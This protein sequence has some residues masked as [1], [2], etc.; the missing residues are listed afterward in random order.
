MANIEGPPQ[1]TA[2]ARRSQRTRS[3]N[4]AL[5]ALLSIHIG[6]RDHDLLPLRSGGITED[7]R[8]LVRYRRELVKVRNRHINYTAGLDCRINGLVVEI[9]AT[10]VAGTALTDIHDIQQIAHTLLTCQVLREATP[11]TVRFRR[12]T[13][14]TNRHLTP[15]DSPYAAIMIQSPPEGL[16]NIIREG[17]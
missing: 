11:A 16:C 17:M 13:E 12:T 5:D 3:E 10:A 6:T 2:H 7:L 15:P 14:L 9:A 1:M 8:C 4:D